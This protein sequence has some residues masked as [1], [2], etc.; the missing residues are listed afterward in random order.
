MWETYHFL[1]KCM[2][3]YLIDRST[4]CHEV[5]N[6]VALH[7]KHQ[8]GNF[9]DEWQACGLTKTDP[10]ELKR[11][12]INMNLKF[13]WRYEVVPSKT[14][15][16]VASSQ[17]GKLSCRERE[18]N[19]IRCPLQSTPVPLQTDSKREREKERRAVNAKSI[20]K[21][22]LARQSRQQLTPCTCMPD[23]VV[24]LHLSCV[25]VWAS[26]SAD[27]SDLSTLL[28]DSSVSIH[29]I[30]YHSIFLV[31]INSSWREHNLK[32]KLNS[33]LVIN[34]TDNTQARPVKLNYCHL[35]LTSTLLYCLS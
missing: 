22:E 4:L 10:S 27:K 31:I 21:L 20:F 30:H 2:V 19:K 23:W 35:K 33:S 18:A 3:I 15:T 5:T 1:V 13:N 14:P 12:D 16:Q 17:T 28:I 6:I 9:I 29:Q 26:V 25:G 11:F 8:V 32:R 24:A 7:S 34:T